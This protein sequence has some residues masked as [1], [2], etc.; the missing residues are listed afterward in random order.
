[1]KFTSSHC[2]P[3]SHQSSCAQFALME[4][5]SQVMSF[6]PVPKTLWISEI[7]GKLHTSRQSISKQRSNFPSP[8]LHPRHCVSNC[9]KPR[10]QL[11]LSWICLTS[12]VLLGSGKGRRL[13]W[14]GAT[15][16]RDMSS[17]SSAALASLPSCVHFKRLRFNQKRRVMILNHLLKHMAN[18]W[19]AREE[20]FKN[21]L[22][23]SG[24]TRKLCVLSWLWTQIRPSWG[25]WAF[26]QDPNMHPA[27]SAFGK[28][29]MFRYVCLFG[30]MVKRAKAVSR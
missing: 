19:V 29:V 4:G 24:G 5:K 8:Q 21:S 10:L 14:S 25:Q 11:S 12:P 27:F 16:G 3:E 26:V 9:L 13:V 2:I 1:M 18:P 6:V 20:H 22:K 7:E 17:W 28:G 30:V 15:D 23:S